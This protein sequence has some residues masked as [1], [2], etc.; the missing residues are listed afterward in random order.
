[1]SVPAQRFSL[2]S[3]KRSTLIAVLVVLVP[4][5]GALGGAWATVLSEAVLVTAQAGT[6]V[7]HRALFRRMRAGESPV[8][9]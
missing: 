7:A 4:R 9:S 5:L 2:P 1:M 3:V 8:R 6:L